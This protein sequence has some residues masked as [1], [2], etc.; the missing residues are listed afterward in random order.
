MSIKVLVAILGQEVVDQMTPDQ[1]RN[2]AN[3][4]DDEILA[5]EQ[6]ASRLSKIVT[7]AARRVRGTNSD[8]LGA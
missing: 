4:L 6:L 3:I 2:L 8:P 5:D 7:K 1:V